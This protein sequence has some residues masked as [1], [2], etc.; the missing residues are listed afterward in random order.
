[1]ID[2]LAGRLVVECFLQLKF[3]RIRL[4]PLLLLL[5]LLGQTARENGAPSYSS[6][7]TNSA[8]SPAAELAV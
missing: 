6:R 2:G 8:C 7:R 4:L 1:M 3:A 5:L